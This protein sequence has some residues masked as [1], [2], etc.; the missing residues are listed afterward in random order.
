MSNFVIE[1]ISS[2]PIG[3]R[4]R[5]IREARGLSQRQLARLARGVSYGYVSRIENNQRDISLAGIRELARIL[6][7]NPVYIET[8]KLEECPHCLRKF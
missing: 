6:D 8:G 7:V 3:Q 2:L 4:I 1:D 5:W